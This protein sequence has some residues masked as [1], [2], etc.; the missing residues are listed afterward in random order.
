[1]LI[2]NYHTTFAGTAAM[3]LGTDLNSKKGDGNAPSPFF[4]SFFP[5]YATDFAKGAHVPRAS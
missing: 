1:M 3:K 5:V 4:V 2:I